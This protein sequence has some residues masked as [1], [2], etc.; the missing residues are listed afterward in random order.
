MPGTMECGFSLSIQNQWISYVHAN[1]LNRSNILWWCCCWWH[2]NYVQLIQIL[3][4]GIKQPLRKLP[5][6]MTKFLSLNSKSSH[7]MQWSNAFEC[8]LKSSFLHTITGEIKHDIDQTFTLAYT[9]FM[10]FPLD[11]IAISQGLWSNQTHF[12]LWLLVDS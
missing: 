1:P 11:Q 8:I 9:N 5:K 6:S 12:N 2:I 7:K 10:H 4:P 3:I